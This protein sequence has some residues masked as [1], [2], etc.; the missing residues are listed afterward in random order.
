MDDV[1]TAYK[2]SR[3]AKYKGLKDD[4]MMRQMERNVKLTEHHL[5]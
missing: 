4:E 5:E 2:K 1:G 3:V